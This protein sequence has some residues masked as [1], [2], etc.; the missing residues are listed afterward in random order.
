MKRVVLAIV[1]A[2][3]VAGACDTG[4]DGTAFKC[5]DG[6]ACPEDQQCISGRC[7]SVAPVSI[8]CGDATCSP[9]QQCCADVINGNRCI[10]AIDDCVGT[11]ALCDGPDDCA[12]GETCCNADTLTR[13]FAAC[14]ASAAC[15]VA[16]DC[17]S[18]APNCCPQA[19]VPW[20]RCQLTPC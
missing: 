12:S 1:I 18:D 20:G 14:D 16:A 9:D 13:C 5:R 7:R 4:H 3:A 19:V 17:P 2:V 8:A 11:A 6:D 10:P 15:A